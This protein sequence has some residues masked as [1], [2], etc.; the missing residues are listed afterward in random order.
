MRNWIRKQ[1]LKTGWDIRRVSSYKK[2][3]QEQTLARERQKWAF[4]EQ[5]K[6]QTI[7]DIGANIGQYAQLVRPICPQAKIISFEPLL[8]CYERLKELSEELKPHE[9]VH[10]ALGTEDCI[11]IIHKNDYS[12]SSSLLEMEKLHYEQLPHT[13]NT[14]EE[15]VK[16]QRLD[17]IAPTL[18]WEYPL[19]I[20]VDVQ[21][22]EKQVLIGGEKTIR[23]AQAI[24]LEV[25]AY[26]LYRGEAGFDAIYELLRAWGF[27]YRGNVDHWVSPTDKRIM[28][29]DCLFENEQLNKIP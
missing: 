28:Q 5:M 26:P 15:K 20:K 4:L 1:V 3:K 10:T 19:F 7:L 13:A 14:S 8:Q 12:P 16:V 2:L 17:D 9:V 29:F 6:P 22:F 27:C 25:S 24:V 23:Q 11:S 18:N 21:G